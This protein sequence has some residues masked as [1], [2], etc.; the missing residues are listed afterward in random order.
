[1]M[2]ADDRHRRLAYGDSGDEDD[3]DGG[4]DDD[5]YVATVPHSL[6]ARITG[7]VAQAL[8]Y[9]ESK[10]VAH[11]DIKPEVRNTNRDC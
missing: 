8:L 2:L 9:L 10:N 1:M 7:Q 4:D 3:G 5:Q 11:R 6:A